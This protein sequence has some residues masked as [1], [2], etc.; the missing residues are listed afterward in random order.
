MLRD[1]DREILQAWIRSTTMRSGLFLRARIIILAADGAAHAEIG[2]WFEI[3]RQAQGSTGGPA[4]SHTGPMDFTKNIDQGVHGP[5][6]G[7]H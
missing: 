6:T 7:T 2:R 3:S 1:G 5:W 4:T